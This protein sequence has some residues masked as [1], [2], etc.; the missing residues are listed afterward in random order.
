MLVFTL[1]AAHAQKP[2]IRDVPFAQEYSKP[3]PPLPTPEEND[4]RAV[5]PMVTR[6]GRVWV[7]TAA[8]VR[9]W[10]LGRWHTPADNV[11]PAFCI[12][13]YHLAFVGTWNGVYRAESDKLIPMGLQGHPISAIHVQSFTGT[14]N[15]TLYA[16]SP[17]GI[18]RAENV[19]YQE[20]PKWQKLDGVW[21]N[22]IRAIYA[23]DTR[24]WIGTASGLF[25]W[26]L[27]GSERITEFWNKPEQI[28]SSSIRSI[29]ADRQGRV[30]V[31]TS[32]G[33]DV[34]DKG[35]RIKTHTV[36]NGLPN[37]DI[38]ALA[39]DNKGRLWAATRLGAIRYDGKRWILRHSRRWLL[40]NE[41][42]S[43]GVNE[44]NT[45][46]IGTAKG[47]SSIAE[48]Q[49]TLADKADYY[50]K[51]VRTRH[52]RPPGLIGPAM[53]KTPGDLRDYFVMDTDNDGEHTGYYCA[54]ESYRYAVTKDKSAYDNAREA[55]LALEQ[56]NLV[57]GTKHF[58]ARTMIPINSLPQN[59]VNRTF[60]P[61]QQAEERANDLRFK[62]VEERWLPSKDGKWLWKRDTSSDEVSG[63]LFGAYVFYRIA[64]TEAD[65]K[66]VAAYMDRL[67][68][69][70]VD[71]DFDLID[72]D[73]K[74]T[75]WGIFS[76]KRLND[77]PDWREERPNNSLEILTY[78]RM[79]AE[80]TGNPR[81]TRAFEELA[82]KHGYVKNANWRDYG[83]PS[84]YTHIV[85]DMNMVTFTGTME[86]EKDPKLRR[87]FQQGMRD[88]HKVIARDQV[89]MYDFVFNA[90]SGKTVPLEGA[91]E[92]L[93]DYPLDLIEWTVDNSQREDVGR[94]KR[95][96]K[97]EGMLNRIL[98]RSE[99]G[100]CPPDQEPYLAVIGNGGQTEDKN[101][102]FPLAYWF[103]RYYG[104]ITSP[105]AR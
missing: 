31:G 28:S 78:L 38:R 41:T 81:Y 21:R 51:I 9:L 4:I 53:L 27:D 1:S 8:G 57:T 97:D 100:I 76:P 45:V 91:A 15:E 70:L 6:P 29:I 50:A 87:H 44:D 24:L 5:Y 32:G 40:D 64:A 43:I 26:K 23:D 13:G 68:G 85:D 65:K 105:Q 73:G 92:Q 17:D 66:I 2:I 86:V 80:V 58:I 84:E 69:G 77:D 52:I 93:R 55:F 25:R 19:T 101:D 10:D 12:G 103:G 18:W 63:H 3:L 75:R 35:K 47:V 88:W 56:L 95:P 14:D 83:I 99:M 34:F 90:F 74:P 54:T 42:R 30:Y 20:P 46:F 67:V 104:L 33:I 49:M 98:P 94:D 11:A 82:T 59:D 16:A 72:I 39:F 48:R 60:S 36:S 62:A 96:G 37:R 79:A 22:T 102:A 71:N 7:A 89:P 61:E